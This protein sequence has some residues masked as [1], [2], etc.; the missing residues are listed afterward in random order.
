LEFVTTA[1]IAAATLERHRKEKMMGNLV[2]RFNQA[3]H[4][5]NLRNDEWHVNTDVLAAVALSS[6]YGGLLLRAKYC[7]DLSAYRQL[8]DK[9]TWIVSTKAERQNWPVHIPIDTVARISLAMWGD[10]VCKACAGRK[11]ETIFNTS[12]LS[13]K[14][15]R[16]CKGTGKAQFQGDPRLRD[17]VLDMVEELNADERKAIARAQKKLGTESSTYPPCLHLKKRA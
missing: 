1:A 4:S 12:K 7:E 3:V 16:L 8:K 11:K 13:T 15:C 5:N 2:L 6:K 17:Y 14:D 9:W 10:Q